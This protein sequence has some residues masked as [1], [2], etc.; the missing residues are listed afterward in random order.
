MLYH[1]LK[2][3]F[4]DL[5]PLFK[6]FIEVLSTTIGINDI[7]IFF[8]RFAQEKTPQNKFT[9]QNSVYKIT[10]FLPRT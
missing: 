10:D 8:I 9:C 2:F 6:I 5:A 7:Y 3:I 4:Q 1:L